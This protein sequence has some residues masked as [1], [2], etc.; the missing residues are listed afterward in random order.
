MQEKENTEAKH[1]SFNNK[2]TYSNYFAN[3]K[4][5]TAASSLYYGRERNPA[6]YDYYKIQERVIVFCFAF[7]SKFL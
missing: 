7:A 1:N 4:T 3:A 2:K 5:M 6:C